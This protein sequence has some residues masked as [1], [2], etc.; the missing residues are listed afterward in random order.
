MQHSKI[1]SPSNPMIKELVRL[2]DRKGVMADTKFLVEGA[3]EAIRASKCNFVLDQLFYC[4]SLESE[5]ANILLKQF[6]NPVEISIEA[7]QKIATRENKDGILAVFKQKVMSLEKLKP[8]IPNRPF[9][10]I[11]VEDIEKPGNLGAVLRSADAADVDAVVVIDQRVDVWNQNVIRSSLGGLFHVPI[12]QC[13]L[14][15]FVS[16]CK[17]RK[18]SIIGAALSDKTVNY[19]SVDYIQDIAIMLGS[20]ANGL[21]KDALQHC[22]THTKIPMHGICDSLNISVAAAVFMYEVLRQRSI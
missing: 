7:F 14:P 19:T 16:F 12:V 5:D 10:L 13:T 9:H 18:I 20:E 22:K 6:A 4:P 1:Q 17:N 11:A 15:E 21:S 8:K 3:R 2:K